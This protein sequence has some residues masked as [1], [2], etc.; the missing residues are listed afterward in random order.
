MKC[1]NFNCRKEIKK[2]P[3]VKYDEFSGLKLY[4]CSDDCNMFWWFF[5]NIKDRHRIP[6]IHRGWIPSLEKNFRKFYDFMPEKFFDFLKKKEVKIIKTKFNI[7]EV[8][9][10]AISY[11]RDCETGYR[12]TFKDWYNN[13]SPGWEEIANK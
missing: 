3:H 8:S 13:I 12:G 9:Y 1:D 5:C 2:V 6:Y 11:V 4:F 7:E 10:I